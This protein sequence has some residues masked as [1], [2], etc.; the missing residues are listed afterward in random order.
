MIFEA[1]TSSGTWYASNATNNEAES[2]GFWNLETKATGG[3]SQYRFFVGG[4]SFYLKVLNDITIGAGSNIHSS[5][6]TSKLRHYGPFFN[7]EGAAAF[8]NVTDVECGLITIGS[9]GELEFNNGDQ[10][11][12]CTG[13]RNLRGAAGISA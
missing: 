7:I 1:D 6:G 8:D 13:I 2:I 5:N 12:S 3:A 11:I 10:S 4:N 9:S